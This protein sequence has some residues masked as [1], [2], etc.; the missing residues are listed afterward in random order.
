MNNIKNKAM[1]GDPDAFGELVTSREYTN[2]LYRVARSFLNEEDAADAIQ[3]TILIAWEKIYSLRQSEYFKTWL[4]RILINVCKKISSE[5]KQLLF[6][7][8]APEVIDRA[9]IEGDITSKTEFERLMNCISPTNRT[10]LELY[11]GE[12]MKISEIAFLL[13]LEESA[14]RKRL[15]RGRKEVEKYVG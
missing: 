11:Y 14:V 8:N 5:R 4:I 6:Q 15:S 9:D 13:D 7:E 3:E 2:S 12:E 10:V 1:R